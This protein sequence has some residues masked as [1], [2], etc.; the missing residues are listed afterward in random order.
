MSILE[1]TI[2][3][4]ETDVRI[5][6]LGTGA[7]AWGDRFVWGY[8]R[9]FGLEQVREAFH[10]SIEHGVNFFDTAEVYGMGRSERHL[11]KFIQETDE[12]VIVATKFFPSYPWR[13]R[14]GAL[15][16]ALESS[17]DR[18]G[19]KQVDLY[20]VHNPFPAFLQDTWSRD[21]A[22]AVQRGLTRT[23]GVS[24]YN[25]E[26]TLRAHEV[27]TRNGM[28]LAS[29][30]VEYSL[31]NRKIER[32]GTLQACRET[33]ATVIAYSPLG[34][35]LLTGKYTPDNPLSGARRWKY[36]G[37]YLRRI[38]PLIDLMRAI[39]K[40]HGGKTPAQVSLNWLVCK[41]TVP[42][43]GAK[44]SRQAGDNAGALGWRLRQ[45]EIAALDE[46]SSNIQ[47]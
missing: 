44:N 40:Q 18:L 8:G 21:L 45:D 43:P 12:P 47:T 28:P 30:Q 26:Q 22:E 20:Q 34:M 24:N 36:G 14:Q 6:P 41:D 3:L 46:A 10:A 23:V 1:D 11:G 4:G 33:G 35:G 7:W 39:G 29:N 5:Q 38:Q 15:L 19:M 13:F 17:L 37:S 25:R 27:L 31:L 9:G 42:I 16:H 32:D 2:T